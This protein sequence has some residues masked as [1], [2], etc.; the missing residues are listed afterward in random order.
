MKTSACNSNAFSKR[1][2]AAALVFV[3]A[4]VLITTSHVSRAAF[5]EKQ[6]RIFENTIPAHIPIEIKVK[7]EKENSFKDLKNEKWLR[8]F[9]L[10]VTN[11]GDKPIYYLDIAMDTDVGYEVGGPK[12][13]Y[14]L[15]YGRLELSDIV[16]KATTDDVPIKPAEKTIL[17]VQGA[18]LWEKGVREKRWPE[19]TRFKAHIQILSFGDGTGYFVW[20]LYPEPDRRK[21]EEER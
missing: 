7:K 5:Q 9:E 2:S 8:E 18:E 11:T 20:S 13:G 16:T 3:V 19:A 1:L 14:S 15:R 4:G 6:E 10:E 17:T 21:G 12:I